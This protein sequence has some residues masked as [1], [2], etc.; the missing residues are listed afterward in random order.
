M[1]KA[2]IENASVV[3]LGSFN[4]AIFQPAWFGAQGLITG[5]EVTAAKL[6][7]VHPEIAIFSTAWFSLQVTSDRFQI[8]TVTP[9]SYPLLRDL[10]TGTFTILSQT[11]VARM[12]LNTR[13][14]Y[15]FDAE[16]KWHA[17]GHLLAPKEP[18]AGV[19]NAPGMRA[20]VM[21]GQR[22]GTAASKIEVRVESE[23]HGRP[24][25]RIFVATNHDYVLR[26]EGGTLHI[27]ELI[28]AEWD[29]ILAYGRTTAESLLRVGMP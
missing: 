6:G 28:T 27:C 14:H 26:G 18:W 19:L 25:Y 22:E 23:S 29:D 2:E 12:G 10:V 3:V 17:V 24:D 9:D 21:W 5:E 8:E 4:P 1:M 13:R 20:L 15:R 16:E 11:P 7:M